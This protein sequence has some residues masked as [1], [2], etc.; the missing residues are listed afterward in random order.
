MYKLCPLR[1]ETIVIHNRVTDFNTV[2]IGINIVSDN[3]IYKTRF[4][5]CIENECMLFNTITKRCEYMKGD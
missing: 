4:L 1:T 2:P 3:D 5:P